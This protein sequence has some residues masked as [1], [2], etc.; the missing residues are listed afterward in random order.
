MAITN[1]DWAGLPVRTVLPA[2]H[3]ALADPGCAV[4]VAPPGA[5]KST[6]VPLALRDAAWL[7]AARI[8][9]LEPRRLAARAVA[10]RMAEMLGEAVGETVGYRTRLERRVGAATR[11]EVV[12]EGI[13]TRWLQQDPALDGTGLVIFDEFH[14][15]SLQADLGLALTLDARSHLNPALRVLVMSATLDGARVAALLDDAPLL[16]A[17]G[18]SFPVTTHHLAPHRARGPAPPPEALACQAVRRALDTEEGD[19]L[20][21]LPGAGEIRRVGAALGEA[22]LPRGIDVRPLHGDLPRET[23]DLALRPAPPGIRKVVLATNIA[24][25]SLTIDGVRVVIDSGLERRPRFDPASGMSHLERARIS[26]SSA[27]QRRGRAGRLGPGTCHRLWTAAEERTLAAFAPAEILVADL[28]PLALE[29][30]CW[31]VADVGALRWLD[32]PPAGALAQGWS[33]LATLGAVDAKGHITAAGRAMARLG[34]HPRLAHLLL[35]GHEQGRT[36]TACAL[37]ALLSERDLPGMDDHDADIRTRLDRLQREAH[38]D[39]IVLRSAALHARRLGAPW[40][41]RDICSGDAGPLLA[42]AYPDR[43]ARSRGGDSRYQLASGH[44][45]AFGRADALARR[46]YLVVARL[47]GGER[48]ARIRLAAPI[49]R[50]EI[51]AA[52]AASIHIVTDVAWDPRTEAVNAMCR[53]RL[54]ALLLDESPLAGVDAGAM[55]HAMLDGIRQLGVA[56]LPWTPALRQWQARVRFATRHDTGMAWPTLEDD[57]LL[58]DLDDWLGDR[59]DG[60]SRRSHLAR[61]DLAGALHARLSWAQRQRLDELA[62]THLTVPSGSRIAL[63]YLDGEAPSLSVRLQELFGLDDSPRIAGGRVTVLVKLLSPAGRPLQVT[64]DL[65]GFWRGSYQDVRREMRGRY[66][67]HPWPEDP[68]NAEA[69]RRAKPRG[70]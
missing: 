28:A 23:Q 4:L 29:L 43:I 8:V 20:V 33:L 41:A 46:E 35:R 34:S 58:A 12:T 36:A 68:L 10:T 11:I 16:T 38:R 37:A 24:E 49:A 52:C 21:F 14:E 64:R 55:R 65:A 44:G 48:E 7:G 40:S 69:T 54:G 47:D 30:A 70:R 51:D 31:G 25:T 3:A 27:D 66:P 59:L 1:D 15:R 32:A 56:A 22:G 63:D 62:P 19:V 17:E 61:L 50:T 42:L 5:G 45:A 13:L 26:L 57:A 39:A 2:L 53:T 18:L 60:I 6:V 67:R 9:M